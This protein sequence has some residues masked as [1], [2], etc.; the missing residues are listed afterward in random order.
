MDQKPIKGL[1]YLLKKYWAVTIIPSFLLYCVYADYTHTQKWKA[2]L[3][4]KNEQ[5]Q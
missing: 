3:A 1:G 2:S 5:L 4:L